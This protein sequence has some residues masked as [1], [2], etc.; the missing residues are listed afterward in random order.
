MSNAINTVTQAEN[1]M[2]YSNI[3]YEMLIGT[4]GKLP[5][6]GAKGPRTGV[7]FYE[8][9]TNYCI[10]TFGRSIGKS[11][12]TAAKNEAIELGAAVH[13][14]KVIKRVTRVKPVVHPTMY[15]NDASAAERRLAEQY[16]HLS[17]LEVANFVCDGWSKIVY[18]RKVTAG[19]LKSF[20]GR[21]ELIRYHRF[22]LLMAL[23][24][25]IDPTAAA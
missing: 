7:G 4:F 17:D 16:N 14:P 1:A 23:G 21:G 2:I 24:K 25:E 5:T 18:R 8:Q 3:R 13:Q 11:V 6:A 22:T 15:P 12:I 10:E 20:A 19:I 9:V